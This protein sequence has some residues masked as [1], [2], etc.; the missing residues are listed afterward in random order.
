VKREI[1]ASRIKVCLDIVLEVKALVVRECIKR[2]NNPDNRWRGFI[3]SHPVERLKKNNNKIIIHDNF[4]RDFLRFTHI[5]DEKNIK[6]VRGDVSALPCPE[7]GLKW[8]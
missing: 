7:I 3:G 8:F 6:V 5:T 1:S 4:R 2:Q